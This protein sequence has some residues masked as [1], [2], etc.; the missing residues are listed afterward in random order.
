MRVGVEVGGTFTDLVLIEDGK[1]RVAK[2]P[3]TPKNP[4]EGA[5]KA[6][7]IAGISPSSIE[8]LVH[9]STVATNAVLER[10]GAKVCFF[11]TQGTRDILMLQRHDK[12]SIYDLHYHKPEPVASRRDTFEISER[13]DADGNVVR[14]LDEAVV[15]GIV[16]A[17]LGS[18]DFDAV[19]ICFLNGYINPSHEE[20]VARIV[21]DVDPRISITCSHEVTREFREYERASTTTLA[22]YVQPVIEGYLGR[23]VE[24]L[25]EKGFAGQFSV[26]QSNGGR[27]PAEAMARNA[28]A[29]LF[30]G[31][32]AGVIGALRQVEASG[33]R[34]L[35]TLDMGGTSTDVSLISDGVPDLA[36]MTK[37]DGLPVKT[38]VI[39]IVT[40]GAG[41][42]SI[43]WIDDGGLLRVG[44]KSAGADP[45]PACYGRGGAVP[46]V[47]DAHMIRG[48]VRAGSFLGGQ[49][50]V[51]PEASRTVFV[52]MAKE[53]AMGVEELADS[54]IQIAESNIVRAIQQV[55]TERGRD[56]RGY[57]IVPFGGAGPLHAARVAEELGVTTVIVPPHAGVLSAAGLLMSDYIHYRARTRKLRLDQ[58]AVGDVREVLDALEGEVSAYLQSL[59]IDGDVE[60]DRALEMRYVGQ[61]FEVTVPLS[62]SDASGMTAERLSGLFGE[63]HHR[64]FEFSKPPNDPVEIVSFRVGAKVAPTAIPNL[65]DGFTATN[66]EGIDIDM[67]DRGE[68]LTCRVLPRSAVPAT[69]MA[70]PLLI[71][72]GTSTI[73]APPG[74]VTATDPH[75]NIVMKHEEG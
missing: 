31:P 64:I 19:A 69:A 38:P 54:I 52:A 25:A 71:E 53:I 46:T 28:I 43:G 27:V 51:D 74:W 21:R 75:G 17:A 6:I 12:N 56:P 9:G 40:V 14:V 30:S 18:G 44:P 2:V 8:D 48:S 10:K 26:M 58:A 16:E 61:A 22:A 60:Y 63:E 13:M 24:A 62:E 3:S 42:G 59:G 57:A 29:A 50:K 20:A 68:R 39:D 11:V 66:E 70:G 49:M 5:L 73:Y 55:S 67:L 65:G 35:I 32:A 34:D 23:F 15:T 1:L 47:T 72:D 41:G 7:E 37:I 4:D 36:P 45:G 33:T